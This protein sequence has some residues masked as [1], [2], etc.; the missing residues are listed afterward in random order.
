MT[1]DEFWSLVQ[2]GVVVTAFFAVILIFVYLAY[3]KPSS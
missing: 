3:E 2:L 1:T